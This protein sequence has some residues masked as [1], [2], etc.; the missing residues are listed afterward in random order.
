MKHYPYNGM[1][2]YVGNPSFGYEE[3]LDQEDS[4]TNP[5]FHWADGTKVGTDI[6]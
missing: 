6:S 5:D 2:V 3:M 1:Q 4:V